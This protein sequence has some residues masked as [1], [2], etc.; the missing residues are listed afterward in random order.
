MAAALIIGGARRSAQRR[1]HQQPHR[2]AAWR[3]LASALGGALIARHGI[4]GILAA[5]SLALIAR[6]RRKAASAALA[7]LA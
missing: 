5:S 1:R 7:A 2:G 6:H 3:G 4:I